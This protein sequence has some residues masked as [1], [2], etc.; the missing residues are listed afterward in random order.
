VSGDSPQTHRLTATERSKITSGSTNGHDW[1]LWRYAAVRQDGSEIT[2]KLVSL[3]VIPLHQE[4][5]V[6]V[7]RRDDPK[8]GP[9]YS[10]KLP[11]RSVQTR[12]AELEER[13]A[14]LERSPT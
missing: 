11:K 6:E 12:L 9:S 5:D 14:R 7:E 2:E 8:Y 13:V 3:D 10:L 4:I 1:T